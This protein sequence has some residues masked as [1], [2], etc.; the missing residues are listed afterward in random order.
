MKLVQLSNIDNSRIVGLVLE[1]KVF[2]ITKVNNEFET[3]YKLIN[4]SITNNQN[5][6]ELLN[7][8][9]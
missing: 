1:N 6:D 7:K 9:S 5:L 2:N 3:T 4:Y 8:S